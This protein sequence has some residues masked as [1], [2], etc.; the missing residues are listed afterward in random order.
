MWPFKKKEPEKKIET[1]ASKKGEVYVEGIKKVSVDKEYNYLV[2]LNLIEDGTILRRAPF[3]AKRY[4]DGANVYLINEKEGFKEPFPTNTQDYKD[5]TLKEVENRIS[6]LQDKLD[7]VRNNKKIKNKRVTSEELDILTDI[8]RFKSYQLSHIRQGQGSYMVISQEQE[9]RPLYTFDMVGTFKL[10]VYKNTDH[11]LLYIPTES[12]IATAGELLK[13]NDDENGS[14]DNMIKL[15]TVIMAVVL[16]LA[17]C[18]V[19]WIGYKTATLPVGLTDSLVSLTDS[20]TNLVNSM[21]TLVQEFGNF[22]QDIGLKP[23]TPTVEP[24]GVQVNN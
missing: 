13:L 8:K 23:E 1:E 17:I 6:Q 2:Q 12:D 7:K 4:V 9:G 24:A 3:G 22:T 20:N 5:Y 16:G 21:N 15:V 11:S 14:K 10:P 19:G 18:A